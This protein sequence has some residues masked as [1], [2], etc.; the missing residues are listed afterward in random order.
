MKGLRKVGKF[1]RDLRASFEKDL[2]SNRSPV[3]S[4]V[5]IIFE[6]MSRTIMTIKFSISSTHFYIYSHT[7]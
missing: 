2:T 1:K 6:L 3:L 4:K 7:V 5:K